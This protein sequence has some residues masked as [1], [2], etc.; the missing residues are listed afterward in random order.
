MESREVLDSQCLKLLVV[1]GFGSFSSRVFRHRVC[2]VECPEFMRCTDEVVDATC[3]GP[4]VYR[5]WAS[6]TT[7]EMVLQRMSVP[8]LMVYRS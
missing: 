4:S 8:S 6:V 5:R 7:K 1:D 2:G 3:V